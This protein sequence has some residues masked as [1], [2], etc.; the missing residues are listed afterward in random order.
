MWER[1]WQVL[2]PRY[3]A[4]PLRQE[5]HVPVV[6]QRRRVCHFCKRERTGYECTGCG[7]AFH[8]LCFEAR[9]DR[10]VT[11]SEVALCGT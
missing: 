1:Q 8:V 7:K 10:E 4:Q 5:V 6:I 3:F 11:L 9:W 2:R